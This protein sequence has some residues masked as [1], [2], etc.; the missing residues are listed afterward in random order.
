MLQ[1]TTSQIKVAKMRKRVRILQG[2]TSSSKTFTIIPMLI[3]YAIQKPGSEISIVGETI[4]NLR[5]GAIR[6]FLKIMEWTNNMVEE[7][8]NRSTLTYNFPNGSFI[9][10]FSAD[11]VDKLR[12]PRRD[13]LFIN[14]ANNV[15]FEAYQQLAIRTRKFIYLD[16]NPS[17]E[18][19][20]HTELMGQD[21][22]DFCIL[23]YKDN[24]ALEPAIIKEIERAKGK[25]YINP[26]LS[27]GEINHEANIKNTFW[28]NWWRVYGLGQ[29]GSLQGTVYN[30]WTQVDN[31]PRDAKYL[32]TGLDFGWQS[33]SAAVDL[34]I[35]NGEIYVDEV[36]YGLEI[37]NS[38]LVRLLRGKE[39]VADS[40]EPRTIHELRMLGLRIRRAEKGPGSKHFGSEL[41]QEYTMHVTKSS[42]N[43]IREL[44]TYVWATDKTGKSLDE[45][46]KENDHAMDALKYVASIKLSRKGSGSY[47]VL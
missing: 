21:D 18:F 19:W 12:G 35:M 43:V 6:D 29:V 28:L 8:W 15:T 32:G 1:R 11:Q 9:E 13:V 41:L 30:N 23:T 20:V 3:T 2:G 46:V 34:Y 25:A 16:F 40:A 37:K 5:R 27:E 26:N 45:P 10:F 24:E 22:A 17:S 47:S 39:V 14:E 4:P 33:P 36:L 42:T 31:I 44:R 7:E 38:D